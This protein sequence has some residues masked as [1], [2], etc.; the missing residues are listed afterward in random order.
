[1]SYS[2]AD[3]GGVINFNAVESTLSRSLGGQIHFLYHCHYFSAIVF[4][5]LYKGSEILT[6][7]FSKLK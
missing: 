6:L 2:D 5:K 4:R 1:M 3:P 7:L